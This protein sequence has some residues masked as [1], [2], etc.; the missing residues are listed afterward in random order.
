VNDAAEYAEEH[1]IKEPPIIVHGKLCNQRR[2][3]AFFGRLSSLL[4][5][6]ARSEGR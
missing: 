3:V 5:D 4:C 2:N 1:L 6:G